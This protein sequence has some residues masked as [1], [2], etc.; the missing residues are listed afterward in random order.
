MWLRLG[1]GLLC[2]IVFYGFVEVGGGGFMYVV[3]RRSIF[4]GGF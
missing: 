4:F 1:G 3:R 2:R